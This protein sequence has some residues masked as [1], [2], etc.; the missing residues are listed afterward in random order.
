VKAINIPALQLI[1]LKAHYFLTIINMQFSDASHKGTSSL[2][3]DMSS[4]T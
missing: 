4:E 2:K 3:G 1:E